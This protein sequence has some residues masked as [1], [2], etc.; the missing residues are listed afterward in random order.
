MS[1]DDF[2]FPRQQEL[3]RL[4]RAQIAAEAAYDAICTVNRSSM[5]EEQRVDYAINRQRAVQVLVKAEQ[6]LATAI[7]EESA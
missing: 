5:S 2:A 3:K 7:R 1:A 4:A 6:A